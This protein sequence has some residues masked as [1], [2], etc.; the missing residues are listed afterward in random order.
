MV[1]TGLFGLEP[2]INRN[3]PDWFNQPLDDLDAVIGRIRR[4][5]EAQLSPNIWQF[6]VPPD[7][8]ALNRDRD[9]QAALG[10]VAMRNIELAPAHLAIAVDRQD[11]GQCRNIVINYLQPSLF[12]WSLWGN[13]TAVWLRDIANMRAWECPPDQGEAVRHVILAVIMVERIYPWDGSRD[14][15]KYA[16]FQKWKDQIRSVLERLLRKDEAEPGRYRDYSDLRLRAP[17]PLHLA[18]PPIPEFP[19]PWFP[20]PVEPVPVPSQPPG[21][22]SE[23]PRPPQPEQPPLLPEPGPVL[24]DPEAFLPDLEPGSA[25]SESSTSSL[26]PPPPRYNLRGTLSNGKGKVAAD[27]PDDPDEGGN[28]N[29][30]PPEDPESDNPKTGPSRPRARDRPRSG[31]TDN[32]EARFRLIQSRGIPYT[33]PCKRCAQSKNKNDNGKPFEC[34]I[35]KQDDEVC[36]YCTKVKEQCGIAMRR[37][38]RDIGNRGVPRPGGRCLNCVR[39]NKSV[40][41]CRVAPTDL[42]ATCGNLCIPCLR[43]EGLPNPKNCKDA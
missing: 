9:Y 38:L 40:A 15:E 5:I 33:P 17:L 26:S 10:S 42:Q 24:S 8:S 35:E 13:S 23:P 43:A 37:K 21:E 39:K 25:P 2:L 29:E 16:A 28:G 34:K 11:W 18:A 36:G 3:A 27:E 1:R 32:A 6:M 12:R 22:P 7:G 41:E 19:T 31:K 4:K 30:P 20:N 14:Y